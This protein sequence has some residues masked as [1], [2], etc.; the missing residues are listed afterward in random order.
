MEDL[1][2]L[3]TVLTDTIRPQRQWHLRLAKVVLLVAS[4][5]L[6]VTAGMAVHERMPAL[7]TIQR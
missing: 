6:L 1:D 5:L 4:A 2:K 7:V 3:R